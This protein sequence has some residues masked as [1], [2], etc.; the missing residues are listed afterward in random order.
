[1]PALIGIT[2]FVV[3]VL[4]AIWATERLLEGLLGLSLA[5]Q[6]SAFAVGAIL[7][8][9]EAEN[10]AIGLAAGARGTAPVA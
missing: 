8:G 7:S 10:L 5:L 6:L 3:G 2:S 9:F 1:M 4:L